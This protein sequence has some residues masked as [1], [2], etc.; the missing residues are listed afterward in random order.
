MGS[1]GR[2]LPPWM[3]EHKQSSTSSSM[4]KLL[5]GV[6]FALSGFVNPERGVL[7]SQ[8]MEMGAEYQTD[9]NPECTL[10]ICAFS[11]T[12]KFRQVV[13]DCGT[14]VSKEW[15]VECYQEK[16]LVAI[17]PYLMHVGKPWRKVTA[18]QET[19]PLNEPQKPVKKD[20]KQK[21]SIVASSESEPAEEDLSPA[22]V[23]K[24]AIDDL[25]ETIAWLESQEERPDTS[26][27]KKIA[28]EGILTCLQDAIESLEQK[29]GIQEMIKQWRFIPRVVKE[30]ARLDDM[31]RSKKSFHGKDLCRR[32][33]ICKRIY[34]TE[35]N[36]AE[37]DSTT[38][39]K[40]KEGHG[41]HGTSSMN[42]GAKASGY[43]YDSDETIE[44]TEDEIDLAYNVVASNISKR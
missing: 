10:L 21:P 44:M 26:D 33:M 38:T 15:I 4:E 37:D 17:E 25:K 2:N 7:R 18:D 36:Q 14:I 22:K 5:D 42:I 27:V 23:K 1:K 12:P 28:S 41:E 30:L 16:K 39:K 34:E 43:A 9:W 11:N 31:D 3:G 24:W 13:A 20:I 35:F 32:A 19:T 8:A 40:K 29:K 6:V